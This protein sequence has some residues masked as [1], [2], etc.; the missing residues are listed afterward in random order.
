V[1][2]ELE[3]SLALAPVEGYSEEVGFLVDWWIRMVGSTWS[4]VV[5]WTLLRLCRMMVQLLDVLGVPILRGLERTV[6][7]ESDL[8]QRGT[9]HLVLRT[10]RALVSGRLVRNLTFPH[11][12]LMR[13]NSR[14]GLVL[15]ALAAQGVDERPH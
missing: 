14:R 5:G 12:W 1:W 9:V 2:G 10:C 6:N 11:S 7:S 15:V 8:G 13:E 4:A 3:V